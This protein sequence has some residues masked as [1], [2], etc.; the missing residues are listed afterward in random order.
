MN[1][2]AIIRV[3]NCLQKCFVDC[4]GVKLVRGTPI[5][6]TPDPGGRLEVTLADAA[7]GLAP[8]DRRRSVGFF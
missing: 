3:W 2:V 6:F 5:R 4:A 8:A 7:R 1:V